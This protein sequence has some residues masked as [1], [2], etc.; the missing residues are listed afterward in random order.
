[1]KHDGVIA[2]GPVGFWARRSPPTWSLSAAARLFDA[3]KGETIIEVGS[4]VHGEMSGDSVLV[5]ARKTAARRVIALDLDAGNIAAVRNATAEHANV[6]A[7]VADGIEYVRTF[8]GRIDLLYLDFWVD[9]AQ[10]A[11]PG[12]ARSEAYG[13][14]YEHARDK[15]APTALLLLDDTDHVHPWKHTEIVPK[16]RADGFRVLW[17]GRQT[18]LVRT[19]PGDDA[20]LDAA[21]EAL[22]LG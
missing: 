12:S 18:L 4:G 8:D 21:V 7:M 14:V 16:A 2:I 22:E 11:L 20:A 6:E 19:R 9:D 13:R 10:G 3:L 5:W 17:E 15:L 1:M